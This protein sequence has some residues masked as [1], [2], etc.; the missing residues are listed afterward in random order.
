MITDFLERGERGSQLLLY[1]NLHDDTAPPN[2]EEVPLLVSMNALPNKMGEEHTVY[3]IKNCKGAVPEPDEQA[4][5]T[6]LDALEYGV[7]PGHSLVMLERIIK[8]VYLPMMDP[9]SS[10]KDMYQPTLSTPRTP[11]STKSGL[12]SPRGTDTGRPGTGLGQNSSGHSTEMKDGEDDVNET[13]R[14][15][16]SINMNKF[17]SQISHSIQQ[18][19]GNVQ[20]PVPEL[21][22]DPANPN[23]TAEKE[24]VLE[25]L[26]GA[27]DEWNAL[28][29]NVIDQ[30]TSKKKANGEAPVSEI[31]FWRDRNAALSALY[32]QLNMENVRN[33]I[34]VMEIAKLNMSLFKKQLQDLLKLYIEAKDNVKFLSTLERHFKNIASGNLT[35]IMETIPSMM[36]SLRMVWVISRHYNKDDR[37]FP[38]LCLIAKDIADKVAKEINIRTIFRRPPD[39][40]S[41]TILKGRR[42]L[43][44]WH[45]QYMAMREKIEQSGTDHRWEFNRAALFDQTIYMSKICVHLEEV[46]EA[47]DQFDK[48]LGPELKKVTG[49]P[50]GI[51]RV[52]ARVR[53]LIKPLEVLPYNVFDKSYA[54]SWD[55]QMQDFHT[56]VEAIEEE[57]KQFIDTR[58]KKLRSSEGAFDL[59]QNFKN[60]ESRET[61]QKQMLAKFTDILIQYQHEVHTVRDIFQAGV[62]DPPISKNQPP[63]AGAIAWMRSL[64]HRMKKPVLRFQEME[65]LLSSEKGKEVCQEYVA[66]AK[67]ICAREDAL[68]AEWTER[69]NE[70]TLRQLKDNIFRTETIVPAA[71]LALALEE[72]EKDPKANDRRRNRRERD[73]D[74]DSVSAS[75]GS[76]AMSRS[77][78][79]YGALSRNAS[80]AGMS[81]YRS[82]HG[83]SRRHNRSRMQGNRSSSPHKRQKDHAEAPQKRIVVNFSP[84]LKQIIRETKYLDRMGLPVPEVAVNL[85]L[86]EKKYYSLVGRLNAMLTSYQAALDMLNPVEKGLLAR[87]IEN[88]QRVLQ[89]GFNPL[90][91][92]ALGIPDFVDACARGIS[93]F[94]TTVKHVQ[95]NAGLISNLVGQIKSAKLVDVA[96]FESRTEVLSIEELNVRL[97]KLRLTVVDDLVRKY[98]SIAPLLKIIEQHVCDTDSGASPQMAEYYRYWEKEI[99][100]ALAEMIAVGMTHFQ[101]IL[102]GHPNSKQRKPLISVVAEMVNPP[103]ILVT[104]NIQ[105]IYKTLSKLLKNIPESAKSFVRWMDGT[106]HECE[107][108]HISDDETMTY[109]FYNDLSKNPVVVTMMLS[110]TQSMQ[111]AIHS[112]DRYVDSWNAYNTQY[113][114]WNP[115]KLASLERLKQKKNDIAYF[116][117][118]LSR[119]TQLRKSVMSS[120]KEKD[121]EFIQLNSYPLVLTICKQSEVWVNRYGEILREIAEHHLSALQR[122]MHRLR[123]DMQQ[124]TTQMQDLKFVLNTLA[125]AQGLS[126]DMEIEFAELAERFRTL[127]MYNIDVKPNDREAAAGIEKEWKDLIALSRRRDVELDDIKDKFTE[128]TKTEVEEF[129]TSMADVRAKFMMEGP[130]AMNMDLDEGLVLMQKTTLEIETMVQRRQTLVLS[131]KLFGLSP[132]SFPDL[133]AMEEEMTRLTVMYG[134]YGR[135]QECVKKWSSMLWGELEVNTLTRGTN[136]TLKELKECDEELKKMSVYGKIHRKVT[137]FKESIPLLS[138]LKNDALRERHWKSLMEATGITF[139]VESKSFTLGKL[140]EMQLN[141]F[142]EQIASITQNA[143]NEA[144]IEK[145][146]AKIRQAWGSNVFVLSPYNGDEAQGYVLQ[147]CSEIQLML[148]DHSVNLQAMS[149]SPFATPFL[150]DLRKW[151]QDLNNIDECI[152]V[153][154]LVQRKWMYLEAIFVGSDDIRLQ[155]P[156]AAK[157][158]DRVDKAF[159][160]IMSVTA[161]NPNVLQASQTDKR[162]EDLRSLSVELDVCQKSLSDYLERKRHA[163]PRFFFI[164]EDELLSILGS[165]DPSSVQ[166]HIFKLFANCKTLH[167]VRGNTA[168]AGMSSE[169]GETYEYRTPVLTEG[170]VENWMTAVETEMQRTL[171][172][173]TKEAVFHYAD[174]DRLEW[175]W[176]NLGMVATVG[177]Q[178]WWTWEVHDAF[179]RVRKG[180]KHGMKTLAGRLTGQLNDLVAAIRDDSIDPM[181]RSK[182]N[183][184]IIIDVH[185]RDIIDR[186]VRDSILDE[187]EFDWESQLRFYWDKEEDDVVIRQC[188]GRFRF[189][190]EYMGLN[191]RLVITPLTD[192]CYMTLTQALTFNLGGSP[193]GPAGTGKT[194]TVKDLAKA[195]GLICIVTNCGEGLDFTAMGEIFSGL[196]QTGAWGCFDEFNRIEVEVLSVVSSQL[197]CIQSA[198]SAKKS[199]FEFQGKDICLKDSVGFFVTMNPGYAGRTELPDSLKAAFRPVTMVV[200][201]MMQIC[202]IMLFSEGFTQARAL[203]KKMTVLYKLAREQL[204]KQYH[205]DFGLRALKSVLVMAGAL[206]RASGEDYGE[207]CVI[208]RAL[209]DMN[210]PKFVF[211]DVPLF[212]G[213]ITDLFPGLDVPRVQQQSLKNA[214]IADLEA[215]GYKHRDTPKFLLQVDKVIQLQET[216][217]TRHTS[218]VVGPTQGGKSVV[219]STLARAQHKA[220]GLHT[221]L[222]PLNPKSC[223]LPELYGVLDTTTR[224]WTDGLLSKIFRDL[225]EPLK[226]DHKEVRYIVFDGDVDALWVE[227]MNSVM[228]DNKLLTLPNGERIRLEDHVKLLFEVADLQYASPATVSRCGMVFVDPKNLGYEPYYSRW[229]AVY[230]GDD[231]KYEQMLYGLFDKYVKPCVDYVISGLVD[232]AV[233]KAGPVENT[234]PLIDL[235]MVKQLCDLFEAILPPEG[236]SG[237][238]VAIAADKALSKSSEEDSESKPSKYVSARD[239]EVIESVFVFCVTWSIGAGLKGSSREKFDQHLKLVAGR[240][241]VA[242]PGKAHLPEESLYEYS[243]PTDTDGPMRWVKW[244]APDYV[245]PSPFQFSKIL[246]PTMDTVRHTYLLEKT[247]QQSKPVLFVGE[248][249]TAKSVTVQNYLNNLDPQANTSLQINFSSRTSSR[250]LQ[251][252]IEAN[253][254]KRTGSVYGPSGGKTMTVFCDDLNMPVVDEYGTQQPIALLLFLVNSNHMYDRGISDDSKAEPLSKKTFRDLRYMAAMAP[255]GGGRAAVDPRLVSIYSVFSIN[256]PSDDQLEKIYSSILRGHL[257]T[258]GFDKDM[259]PCAAKITTMTMSLYTEMV[260]KLP[261]TPSKFHYVFNLRDLSRIYEGVLLSTPATC[262]DSKSM[263]RLWRNECLRVMHDR[264]TTEEDRILVKDTLIAGLINAT[265]KA[266]AAHCLSDP[267]LYGDFKNIHDPT[268]TDPRSYESL[269]DYDMVKTVFDE[270]LRLYNENEDNRKMELVLFQDALEH[271]TRIHRILRLPR[272]HALLV[273]VGGSGKQSLARLAAFANNQKVFQVVLSRSYGETEFREDLKKLYVELGKG[274]NGTPAVFLF[275]DAQVKEDSFLEM[276]NNMLTSGMVPGLFAEEE[277]MPLLD[278]VRAECKD[279]GIPVNKDNMW[280][281]YINKCR[282]CLHVVLCMSPAG[283]ALRLRCRQFPGL[284]SNTV[285]DWFYPWPESAL[286]LVANRFLA[287]EALPDDQRE[288]ITMHM[289]R[290]HQSMGNYSARFLNELRRVNHVTPRNYLDFIQTYKTQLSKT[291]AQNSA[292]FNRLDGGLTKLI[293]AGEAVENFG[294]ELT[295]RKIIVDAKSKEVGEMIVNI[296]ANSKEVEEK[297]AAAVIK[298]Q[299]L[300]EDSAR[301]TIEKA[302]AEEAL[303]E[304]E[305]ALS[306]AAEALNNLKAAD[307]AQVKV[308]PNPPVAVV[309]VLQCVIELQPTGKEDPSQGWVGCKAMMSDPNF[310]RNLRE[311]KKNEITKRQIKQV[312]EI[313][314]KKPQDPKQ[315]LTLDNLKRISSAA[316]GLYQWVVAVVNYNKVLKA[317][318]P[319][320]KK[321]AQMILDQENAASDLAQTKIDLAALTEE[322]EHLRRNYAEKSGEL[323]SL[324]KEAE[325]MEAHLAAASKLISGLS[326][327]KIRWGQ[328]RDKLGD[329]AIRLVGDCLLASAFLCYTGSF[330]FEFRNQMVYE[331]WQS[332]VLERKIPLT[333]PFRLEALLTT[334]VEIAKWGAEGLPADELSVQNGIL[335]TQSSRWPLCIDPQEQAAKWI[336]GREG[337]DKNFRIRSFNDPDFMRMLEVAIQFGNPFL[338]ER[339]NE[340]LDPV[341]DPILEKQ[342]VMQG[343]Q[344]QIVLGDHAIDWN[345][346]FRLYLITKLGNPRYSPEAAGKTMII[347]YAVTMQGLEDQLLNV[348]VGHERADLQQQREELVQSISKN[349]STLAMLED[350]IL[351]ELTESTGN[352]LDNAVLISTL[353]DAKEKSV[354]IAEALLEARTTAEEIDKVTDSYRGAAKRGSILFFSVSGLSAISA[355]YE[356]SLA[357]YLEVFVKALDDSGKE[358]VVAMRVANI[359][360][361]LTKA[362]YDYTCTG[363]F[364]AHKLMYSLNMTALLNTDRM[365]R[366]EMDFFLKGDLSLG[367]PKRANPT[368]FLTEKNWRD[369]LA[370]SELHADK[371]DHPFNK[372]ADSLEGEQDIWKAWYDVE[373]PEETPLPHGLNETLD[374]F[375]KMCILR[376]FRPD[377]V[378]MAVKTF[379]IE[380]MESDYFVQPPVLKYDRIFNQSTPFSPVVFILSAGADPLGELRTVA[381]AKG[382]YPQRFKALALGQGQSKIAEKMLEMGYHRGHWVVLQ[383]CHLLTKWLKTLERILGGLTKPHEDFRLWLT[384]EPTPEF[385]LGILQRALK[386][387]TEP[388]DGMKLNMKTSYSKIQPEELDECPHHAYRPLVYVLTFFHAVVQERRKYGKLGWNVAYDFNAS[389]FSVSRRLLSMYLTKAHNNG[390]EQIPW[391]SL[392][393]LI[394]EA[395]YGGRVTDSFDRRVLISYLEEYMGDFIFDDCQPF[396]FARDDFDYKVPPNGPYEAYTEEIE[397][398]P[399]VNS[400]LMFGLHSNAEIRYN[401]DSVKDLWRNLIDLQPRTASTSSGISREDYISRI[402]QDLVKKVAGKTF[403]LMETRRNLVR[404]TVSGGQERLTQRHSRSRSRSLQARGSRSMSRTASRTADQPASTLEEEIS[405]TLTVLLQE[406]ERWNNLVEKMESSL[407]ELQNALLGI[408]GMSNE[409]DAL[410]S[411]LYD[412][413]LPGAWRKLSPQ[414]EK[415]LGSWMVHFERRYQQY[416]DWAAEAQDPKVMWLAGLHIP[417]AYLTALVQTTCRRRKWP[418]DKSTLYTV[419]TKM[420]SPDEVDR[421]PVDGCYVSGL[422]LEGAAWDHAKGC[423]RRQDPKVLVTELPILQVVPVE[424]NKLKLYNT[425]RTPVYVTQNRRNAMGVG[426]VFEA[427]LTTSVHASHW[428]LQGTALSLNTDS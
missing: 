258:N 18:V 159:K 172:Q 339:V 420:T 279:K 67:A 405:P 410:A 47:L 189:G 285:I 313:L 58:F 21:E 406:L 397:T 403:D 137:G 207:D 372:I 70:V 237:K 83:S 186:F 125:E 351:R 287:T 229:A 223:T 394:G 66:T 104:P 7:L 201:D 12:R 332:D 65:N 194:E 238:A 53:E 174:Q 211:E 263:V 62:N 264:L 222:F 241:C 268:N 288:G 176:N 382:F 46:A 185:A 231:S 118:H 402:A 337:S 57:A 94:E 262:P 389:D 245:P 300:T 71:S 409:L 158:F 378:F 20:L 364:E 35:T 96:A 61:I 233:A 48:F 203:A 175:V 133:F 75:T 232:G 166:L 151:E 379:V 34:K 384:T 27:L 385:P 108:V 190:Y 304:A 324:Q 267:L 341:I 144:K 2:A 115:K 421:M 205:Y 355:M 320:R 45:D 77:T 180:Q 393:Y 16:L 157:R 412:G 329:A 265:F 408:V 214:V 74:R 26:E 10:N 234:I 377:R 257:S 56:K 283:D 78:S 331:D 69:V 395:M 109:T 1:T 243:F 392:R 225:N 50:E 415:G 220:F 342:L 30:E 253:V 139:D 294:K 345:D 230:C 130:G 41:R 221:K 212:K 252:I 38:L 278:S 327:E 85:A 299:K 106:C 240:P 336:K 375:Q 150:P 260:A 165:S 134:I 305:P 350:S 290:V 326:S 179:A 122:K 376:C 136:V 143:M 98:T 107:P 200:P 422:Y 202:E 97:E 242:A 9:E 148:E 37:M 29:A 269:D 281:Y 318:E 370:L 142:K 183:T 63:V 217:Q 168:V 55:Q 154:M 308:M 361:T 32:E 6:M 360:D 356:F 357:S 391:G 248:S 311:Y 121:I 298:E 371:E 124:D 90:N 352:I 315:R 51:E 49:D 14:N 226:P 302:E 227:N 129:K 322:I 188:T 259:D 358:V 114:L 208:M 162:V 102:A 86:Q 310:I 177:S 239:P 44:L 400:P 388:P 301:I 40:V 112:V 316:T 255:P 73:D 113:L 309:A 246:V 178:I 401:T 163:F 215:H 366:S 84:E 407:A 272:G 193:A 418:L 4:D 411:A 362:V 256:F 13:V 427:D 249:G 323:E 110:V 31:N 235:G 381:E 349:H 153:W 328:E 312:N 100:E 380:M 276:V 192:R 149:N 182:L 303:V 250:D 414:T 277:K 22:I 17:A 387:V 428:V 23:A 156:E 271:L 117:R 368:T 396:F 399:L 152:G 81:S 398:I 82:S 204:S 79:S 105:D 54:N 25:S 161:K 390:D 170:A 126:M 289:V 216:M 120:D 325:Q 274:R 128:V 43:E 28:I 196:S 210:M 99:F 135:Q 191:G 171:Q 347:N 404:R 224:D 334:E 244:E 198:L 273:G 306:A 52:L 423:L 321:V 282:N 89:P 275:T 417:E 164:S 184:L 314:K 87:R 340:E 11:R 413:V 80:D 5:S 228:D 251:G 160:K 103:T 92:N 197:N 123:E 132:T 218:M 374:S 199:R 348:V 187:R 42:V 219:I 206:K 330:T 213:L 167:F 169:Q 425:F 426:L 284:V 247:L 354:T 93:A 307:V 270:S 209:R 173:I 292:Q 147:D 335:T 111:H 293:E 33:I 195:L 367:K 145:E 138:S 369:V 280:N 15:E 19:T 317:V 8:D 39:E 68:L 363:L 64:Y 346:D 3:V 119:Y 76:R 127:N 319:R 297:T 36:N 59:L 344:K 116:D 95:K 295:K 24:G 373:K 140:F 131:E 359:K 353:K 101:Q 266:E 333:Q 236:S 424:I 261:P 286:A 91:W 155:L 88:L 254:E 296:K 291:R 60:I 338:L 181:K 343:T 72:K 383:N 146:L 141:K 416:K 386:V 419:V 365:D